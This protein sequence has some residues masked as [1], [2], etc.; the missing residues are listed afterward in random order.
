VPSSS[1]RVIGLNEPA[2][3]TGGRS[4]AGQALV[5]HASFAKYVPVSELERRDEAS[6]GTVAV[7]DLQHFETLLL[8]QLHA[9]GLPNNGVLVDVRERGRMLS[10]V[11]QT[12]EVLDA[13][14]RERSHYLSKMIAAVAVGLF[15]A[16]LNYLW[17]ETVG[18]LR[19]RVANYDLAYFFDIAVKSPERR[20][21]LRTVDDLARI[22]DIELLRAA[23]EI[24]LISD[25]GHAQL[26]HIR[27]MRNYASAA[28]PNQ[29]ELSGLDLASWLETCIRQ[30]ITLPVDNVTAE[31]GRLLANVRSDRLSQDQIR[32]TGAFFDQLPADRADALAAGFFGLYTDAEATPVVQDNVRALWPLLWP[33]VDEPA[34]HEFGTKYARHTANADHPR[35]TAARELLDLVDAQ[36]YLP[37]PIRAS[38]IADAIDSLLAAHHGFDNFYNEV[39]PARQLNTLIGDQGDLPD[40]VA[41]RFVAAL[42]EAFLTNGYG[43]S[44]GAEGYYL[45]MIG[46]LSSQNASRALRTFTLPVVSSKLQQSLPARKFGELLDHLEPKLTSRT[47]RDLLAAIRD[48][49]GS[50]HN[51]PYDAEIKRLL[52]R[53]SS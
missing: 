39:P 6:S 49:S 24:G 27:F 12:V 31:T 22:D 44:H 23:R 25:V 1:C 17:D 26:D 7:S 45:A 14:A 41:D 21:Q 52:G 18:E 3:P 20:K 35:A 32:T 38:E 10:T 13:D 15:D 33:F 5:S 4:Y 51:L 11:D 28:H 47:D 43:A 37:E 40:A 36:A 19:R 8:E 46:S 29:V 42:V 16:A 50:L 30:V 53:T 2:C 48:Y 34:R 9:N